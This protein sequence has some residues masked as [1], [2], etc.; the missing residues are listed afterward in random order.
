[1]ALVISGFFFFLGLFLFQYEILTGV[2]RKGERRG[3]IECW[4]PAQFPEP[5]WGRSLK[6]CSPLKENK[7]QSTKVHFLEVWLPSLTKMSNSFAVRWSYFSSLWLP[8]YLGAHRLLISSY[9][10]LRVY[11]FITSQAVFAK[12]DPISS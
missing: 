5:T 6:L 9:V 8:G 2:E 1:M 12:L 11:R 7:T 3:K 10:Q 4:L